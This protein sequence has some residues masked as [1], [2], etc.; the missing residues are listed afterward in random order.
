MFSDQGKTP[1]GPLSILRYWNRFGF[2]IQ[3]QPSL[4]ST[5]LNLSPGSRCHLRHSQL[6]EFFPCYSITFNLISSHPNPALFI[7]QLS[8][9]PYYRTMRDV[10]KLRPLSLRFISV[11]EIGCRVPSRLTAG[12]A[13]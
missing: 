12:T 9:L 13:A 2:L 10:K 1:A 11:L 4:G 3:P 8:R 7:L 6:L 5:R